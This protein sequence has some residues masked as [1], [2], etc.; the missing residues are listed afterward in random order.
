MPREIDRKLT[1]S[2]PCA[3]AAS[4]SGATAASVASMKLLTWARI[5]YSRSQEILSKNRT[6]FQISSSTWTTGSTGI[7]PVAGDGPMM[8]MFDS[9]NSRTYLL[10]AIFIF[11]ESPPSNRSHRRPAQLFQRVSGTPAEQKLHMRNKV[12]QLLSVVEKSS[13]SGVRYKSDRACTTCNI[14]IR[15]FSTNITTVSTSDLL[16]QP[17]LARNHRAANGERKKRN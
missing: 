1:H 14:P 17:L 13:L 12:L 6:S 2:W 4:N 11:R 9:W 5:M 7:S 3:R 15:R 16:S 10:A 8:F